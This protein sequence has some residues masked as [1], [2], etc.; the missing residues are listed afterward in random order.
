MLETVFFSEKLVVLKWG[1][2]GGWFKMFK[3]VFKHKN[4]GGNS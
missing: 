2:Q 1:H 4:F 3:Y